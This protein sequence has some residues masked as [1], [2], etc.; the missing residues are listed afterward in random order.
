STYFYEKIWS[1]IGSEHDAYWS[2]DKENGDEKAFCCL[3]STSRDFARLGRLILHEGK[4]GEKQV[5]PA[6]YIREMV[7]NEKMETEEGVP[8]SRYGYQIWT[9]HENGKEYIY[10]RGI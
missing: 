4:W 8:N 5:V 3:Y 7:R 6:W 9:Y 2:L 1:Q 10:C